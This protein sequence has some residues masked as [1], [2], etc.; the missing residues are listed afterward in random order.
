MSSANTTNEESNVI[1]VG[2]YIRSN[3]REYGMLIALVAIMVFFQFYTGGILFRPV[4]LT[5]LILQNS[6]IVIMALGMLLVIVAGH[7]DLSV[8]SI[9]AFVGAIAAILTVQWGM[10]PF[11]AALICLVIGGIIGAAQGYW[12]AYHRIPS[13]IVTLAGMLVFRGLTLFVLGG[14]N[15]GPFPTDFQ[16]IS[17]GFLPDIGGIEGLNTTSMILTLLITV[18]LFYLAWRRRVVNVKHGIDVEPFGFFIVQNLLISGAILFLGYQLST[19]R[20]LPN[21]LIV[22]LVL[23]ALYSFVTRRTTIGRRVYAMGGNEKATKLS[24]INTERLS[25]LTFV[26]M[27]V[28]AGLA[29]MIIA[30]RLNSAT[31]KAGVGFELDVIAACF[32]GGASAS[33][34][35]GKITGAVIGAFIMGVMN[36]GMSIVGLGIDFQQMVKGLVLLAAVFFDVYNKNKG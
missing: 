6:F 27:G 2:S 34:G 16:V 33:G 30:T 19:Y 32:I 12:I 18:V 7:I 29:G 3:I 23:I 22:M 25:F 15:I 26:N 20:G 28:L 35:V 1:S 14:K 9:V 24:G 13:F 17:T 36:N 10:N 21:V 4:N 5:N 31:P 11:L 8:G